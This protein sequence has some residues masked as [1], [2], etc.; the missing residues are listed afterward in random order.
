MEYVT[1]V[2][3]FGP[4]P[5]AD[6]HVAATDSATD[7]TTDMWTLEQEYSPAAAG[8]PTAKVH[9]GRVEVTDS[10]AGPVTDVW[11]LGSAPTAESA[12]GTYSPSSAAVVPAAEAEADEPWWEVAVPFFEE[13][14]QAPT[15]DLRDTDMLVA[16]CYEEMRGDHSEADDDIDLIK[17]IKAILPTLNLKRGAKR[18]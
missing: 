12:W 11:T 4:P 17:A 10:A 5:T 1:D 15:V 18:S 14:S 8:T 16:A 9:D 13:M 3:T 2:W 7:P 6:A